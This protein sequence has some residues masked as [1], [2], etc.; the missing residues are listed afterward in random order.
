MP[1]PP[2]SADE[3]LLLLVLPSVVLHTI[4]LVANTF[5]LNVR[6]LTSEVFVHFVYASPG[7]QQALNKHLL[8]GHCVGKSDP[9]GWLVLEQLVL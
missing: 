7:T 4:H 5:Y 3:T 2:A 9:S 1:D 8:N 6:Y